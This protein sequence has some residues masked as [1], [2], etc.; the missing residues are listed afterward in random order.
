ML[1]I[2]ITDAIPIIIASAVKK[3]LVAF[4]LIESRA[5]FID[6]ENNK[7]SP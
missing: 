4:D 2:A 7:I 5:V 1:N 6:S 3:D